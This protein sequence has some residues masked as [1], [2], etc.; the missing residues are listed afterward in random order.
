ML[1]MKHYD[2][3]FK[4]VPPKKNI[5]KKKKN[6]SRR[7]RKMLLPNFVISMDINKSFLQVG[8]KVKDTN[9]EVSA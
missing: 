9:I 2:F 3:F 4:M 5:L 6:R 8:L 1:H 7:E